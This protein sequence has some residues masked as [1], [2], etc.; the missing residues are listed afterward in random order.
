MF[1]Q[2]ALIILSTALV[3]NFVLAKFLGLC[4]VLGVSKNL[5]SA[6]GMSL[7]TAFVLTLTAGLSHII[8]RYL[9]VPFNIEY[10]RII[11]FIVT[12]AATVQFS[13]LFIQKTSPLLHERL[14]VYLPLITTTCAVLGLALLVTQV[15][16]PSIE[17]LFYGFGTAIGFG[18]VLVLF[19]GVREKLE[20]CDVPKPFQGSAIAMITAGIMALAFM[21]V[22][23]MVTL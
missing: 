22:S 19:A 17:S 18:L 6:I 4:P 8:Q 3:N 13:E 7:A 21:G 2:L 11:F 15:P 9:L 20:T 10:L 5:Q 1:K 14:G 23:G 12:I 16:S